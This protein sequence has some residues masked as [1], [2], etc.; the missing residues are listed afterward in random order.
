MIRVRTRGWVIEYN[1]TY[2]LRQKDEYDLLDKKDGNWIASVPGDSII[3]SRDARPHV[4]SRQGTM[5]E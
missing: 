1:A 4:I 2:V 5:F 3:E